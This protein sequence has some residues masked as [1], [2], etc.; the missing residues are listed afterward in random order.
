M[1][2]RIR[3]PDG[4]HANVFTLVVTVPISRLLEVPT[5][6]RLVALLFALLQLAWNDTLTGLFF[7]LL[8]SSVLDYVL[9]RACAK[10]AKRY[11]PR[12]AHDGAL[13]KVSGIAILFIIRGFEAWA[14]SRGFVATHGAIAAAVGV[15]LLL[16]DVESIENH[17]IFLGARP[18]PLLSRVIAWMHGVEARLLGLFPATQATAAER[19]G[20]AEGQPG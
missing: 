9:G 3:R 5:A 16:L 6:A 12:L 19:D 20:G 13:V 1:S 8:G 15:S 17:R 11:D 10:K 14:T 4:R 7:V 2:P 18:I